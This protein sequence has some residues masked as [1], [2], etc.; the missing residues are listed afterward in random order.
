MD[1][2]IVVRYIS[3]RCKSLESE[4]AMMFL[5]PLM[6][7]EFRYTSFLTVV[8][9]RNRDIMSWGF[10][11]TGSNEALCI[12]PRSL[13]LSVKARMLDPCPSCWMVI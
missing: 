13:E 2:K 1:L 5:S 7:W 3:E 6:C 11:S 12:H 8:H 4:S 9:N 10:S